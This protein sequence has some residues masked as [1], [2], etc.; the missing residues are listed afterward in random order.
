MTDFG[1]KKKT[2]TEGIFNFY[3]CSLALLFSNSN[4]SHLLNLAANFVY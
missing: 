1:E 4:F 3:H 2:C